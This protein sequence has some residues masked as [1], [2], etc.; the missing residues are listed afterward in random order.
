L[1][2]WMSARRLLIAAWQNETYRSKNNGKP[3]AF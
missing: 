1:L 3:F 2:F